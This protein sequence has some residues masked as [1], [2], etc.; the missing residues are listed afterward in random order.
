MNLNYS[1]FFE[2]TGLDL[3][4]DE[5]KVIEV[6]HRENL[7]LLDIGS[8]EHFIH[9]CDYQNI[10]W[11]KVDNAISKINKELRKYAL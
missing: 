3:N 11:G 7:P 4:D 9:E 10:H 2:K 6:T 1:I 8:L 5:K